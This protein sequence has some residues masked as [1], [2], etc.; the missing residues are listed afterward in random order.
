MAKSAVSAEQLEVILTNV[1]SK[2][3]PEI[4]IKTLEK[5]ESQMDKLIV[6]FEARFEAKIDK[7][8]SE[9]FA[10]NSRIDLLETKLALQ[11]ASPA[12]PSA[13]KPVSADVAGIVELTTQALIS[14]EKEKEELKIRSR[15][16]IVTGIPPVSSASDRDLFTTFCEENLTIKPHVVHTRRIGKDKNKLCVTLESAEAVDDTL[17]SASLLRNATDD[18]A[19]KVYFNRDLTKLQAQEAY[20]K[21][22]V[23]REKRLHSSATAVKSLN[24]SALPFPSGAS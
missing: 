15:N 11:T 22:C 17:D 21:R 24:P 6:K 20:N 5:L 2:T 8:Y 4:M 1:L 3:L 9:L 18:I 7:L 19:R 12:P 14:M 13:V 23:A 16:I 10:A